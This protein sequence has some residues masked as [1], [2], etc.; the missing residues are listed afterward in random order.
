[1][2]DSPQ[3]TPRE[4]SRLAVRR[5]TKLLAGISLAATG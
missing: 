3:L 1:M 2:P 4:Q 5:L